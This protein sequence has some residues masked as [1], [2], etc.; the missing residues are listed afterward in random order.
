M[1]NIYDFE[2]G[3]LRA[4]YRDAVFFDMMIRKPI[5]QI[6]GDS[7]TGKTLLVSFIKNEKKNA[8]FNTDEDRVSNIAVFDDVVAQKELAAIKDS[9]IIID[10]CDLLLTQEITDFIAADRRNHYLL[11]SRTALPLGLSPNYYGEFVCDSEKVISIHYKF[12]E[13]GWF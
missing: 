5:T 4:A 2:T 8:R 12:S 9:L 6:N 3:R 10:R 7:G 13:T 1:D 11:F